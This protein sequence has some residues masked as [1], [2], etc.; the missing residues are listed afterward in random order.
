[1]LNFFLEKAYDV[2]KFKTKAVAKYP[3]LDHNPPKIESILAFCQDVDEWLRADPNNVAAVHCKAG[4]V[5]FREKMIKGTL[6]FILVFAVFISF[7]FTLFRNFSG[8]HWLDDLLLSA[9][10]SSLPDG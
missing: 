4:K 8:A 9:P 5:R 10:L 3:F 6:S 7:S 1:L 2:D